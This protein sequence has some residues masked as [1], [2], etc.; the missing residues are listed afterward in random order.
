MILLILVSI[1]I[2]NSTTWFDVVST[3]DKGIEQLAFFRNNSTQF[4]IEAGI[5]IPEMLAL[6]EPIV[7]F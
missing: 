3:Y 5:F 4:D 2:F 7:F 6:P 1:P